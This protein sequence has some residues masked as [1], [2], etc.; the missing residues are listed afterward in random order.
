[1]IPRHLMNHR[2]ACHA[3]C[4]EFDDLMRAA[5]LVAATAKS[6][7]DRALADRLRRMAAALLS[8]WRER[9]QHNGRPAP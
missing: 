4:V 8:E 3:R 7:E 6:G 1:M 9:Q 5:A 2:P